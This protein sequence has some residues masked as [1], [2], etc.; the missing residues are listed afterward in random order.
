MKMNYHLARI[1]LWLRHLLL[2]NL[3]TRQRIYKQ[4]DRSTDVSRDREAETDKDKDIDR[5]T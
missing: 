4:R 2:F 1:T 5:Q 3:R